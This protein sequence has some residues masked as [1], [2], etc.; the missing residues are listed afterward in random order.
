MKFKNPLCLLGI[1]LFIQSLFF[2]VA[3]ADFTQPF[4]IKSEGMELRVE[5]VAADFSV[6]WGMAFISKE[7]LLST[8][9]NGSV[10]LF[11]LSDAKKIKLSNTPSVLAMGQVGILAVVLLLMTEAICFS[12]SAIAVNATMHRI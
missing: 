9:R 2:S 5:Q 4:T 10:Y 3:D 7:K 8:E 12:V 1:T 6:P 11:N